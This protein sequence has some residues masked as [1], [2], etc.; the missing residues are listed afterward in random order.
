MS[1]PVVAVAGGPRERGRAYGERARD[2]IHG[3][4]ELYERVFR[5]ATGLRW[6]AVVDR[7]GAFAG[8]IDDYDVRLLPELEGIAEG[9]AVE[10]EDVLA[11]NVRTEVMFGMTA[12]ECTALCTRADA[13][14]D[15]HVLLAQNWDWKPEARATCILLVAMPHDGPPFATFVEAG[16]LA[17]CGLNGAGLG[18][19]ANALTSSLDRGEA[20]VPFHAILRRILSSPSFDEAVDAVTS[21]VRASSANYRVASRDG[22]AADLEAAPGGGRSVTRTDGDRLAHANHFLTAPGGTADR[23]KDLERLDPASSSV[24]RQAAAEAWAAASPARSVDDLLATF[25]DDDAPSA[26][27][28]RPASRPRRPTRRSRPWRWI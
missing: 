3:S 24:A 19:A 20:G 18:V 21:P 7:V 23:G 16:L 9:A 5:H 28:P 11:L 4:L 26:S 6:R 15:A 27:T 22:R 2:R 14:P 10:A 25:A 8:P 1:W 17:K 13:A 12:R